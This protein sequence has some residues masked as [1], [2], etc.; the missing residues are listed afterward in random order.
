MFVGEVLGLLKQLRPFGMAN[1]LMADMAATM[2]ADDI[3]R[4][5]AHHR[6]TKG[7]RGHGEVTQIT[8][9]DKGATRHHRKRGWDR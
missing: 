2:F 5:I 9:A 8:R 7:R 4:L 1:D 3:T 6:A